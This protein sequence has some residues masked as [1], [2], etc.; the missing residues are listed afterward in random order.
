MLFRSRH[1]MLRTTFDVVQGKTL[2]IIHADLPVAIRAGGSIVESRL[3]E[4]IRS[5]IHRPFDLARGPLIRAVIYD[6][7]DRSAVLIVTMHHLVTDGWS[8]GVFV[9]EISACYRAF[10]TGG[11]P[12]LAPLE[13][14]YADFAEWE[15]ERL[16]RLGEQQL[17]Y[18]RAQLRAPVSAT[19]V[20]PDHPR[21]LA[22]SAVGT[23]ECFQLDVLPGARQLAN[24][25]GATLFMVLLAAFEVV[26]RRHTQADETVLGSPVAGRNHADIEP[27]IGFFVN[28][29]V[30]RVDVSGDPTFAELVAR[31]R[32]TT[33]TA[34]DNQDIPFDK[35]VS[36]LKPERPAGR[37]PF[38]DLMFALQNAPRTELELPGLTIEILPVF[39]DTAKFDMTVIC[40]ETQRQLELRIEYDTDLYEA[41]TVRRLAASFEQV[42]RAACA[43]PQAR[44]ESMPVVVPGELEDL[45]GARRGPV[46]NTSPET[47]LTGWFALTAARYPDRVA[48]CWQ[49]EQLTYAA[50]ARRSASLARRQIGR[51]HV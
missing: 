22:P 42:I 44:I 20:L 26:L 12:A 41:V 31:V 36:E 19:E 18:W 35:L 47:T 28:T 49:D 25:L 8:L 33:L 48:V 1:E 27:L 40:E 3:D 34:W 51:A 45:L 11:R 50:L 9:N 30:L 37:R 10:A 29:Q 16:D 38:C 15:R 4:A 13:I 46:L 43:D 17:D 21:P 6:L 23:T 5:E 39:T 7:E 24:G 2:Q 14:Q 32:H